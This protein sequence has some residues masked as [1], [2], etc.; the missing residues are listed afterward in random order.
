MAAWWGKDK[1]PE[2]DQ[3]ERSGGWYADPYGVGARRWYDNKDG[4]TDRVEGVG[5]KP[6]K[7]GVSRLDEAVSR[8]PSNGSGERAREDGA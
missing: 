3:R 7:T 1:V 4:W 2:P 6:D 8:A 5:E